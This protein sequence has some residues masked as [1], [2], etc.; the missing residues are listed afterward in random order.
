M[1]TAWDYGENYILVYSVHS[2]FPLSLVLFGLP[3]EPYSYRSTIIVASIT[4]LFTQRRIQS[5]TILWV[6]PVVWIIGA[7]SYKNLIYDCRLSSYIC[8]DE[9]DYDLD[10]IWCWI[11]YRCWNRPATLTWTSGRKQGNKNSYLKC[12]FFPTIHHIPR[13]IFPELL[14]LV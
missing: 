11:G 5:C 4:I 10:L 14:R 9:R 3:S 12:L 13:S 7:F 8:I 2:I 1:W 6:I